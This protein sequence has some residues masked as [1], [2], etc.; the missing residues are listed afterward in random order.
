MNEKCALVFGAS[1]L[2]GGEIVKQLSE[3]PVYRLVRIFPRSSTG[4]AGLN[5]VEEIITD[6]ED[7]GAQRENIQGD[8]L[9]ICLGTTIKK[10]GSV[11]RMEEIDRDLPVAIAALASVRGVENIAVVSSLGANELSS[12]YYLRIKG[13][14]ENRILA[15]NFK[16]IIIARPS[17]LLGK[18]NEKRFGESAGKV[19]MKFLGKLL[20]GKMGKYRAIEAS[21]VAKAMIRSICSLEGKQILTSDRLQKIAS[22]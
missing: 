2:I 22:E 11:S 7:I 20:I 4:M 10:A 16:T 6:L 17:L 9:F 19:L 3:S 12:N 8:D 21:D 15:L 14:M 1:G 18:R 13:E 5:K